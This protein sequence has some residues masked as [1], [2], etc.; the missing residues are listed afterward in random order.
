MPDLSNDPNALPIPMGVRVDTGAPHPPL[1][2]A[3][4]DRFL[5]GRATAPPATAALARVQS[6]TALGPDGSVA[7]RN[8]LSQTGWAVLFAS[9]AD[10]AIKA[11]LQPLLDLRQRQVAKRAIPG[12][13][14]LFRIFEGTDPATGGV[15]LNPDGTPQTAQQW[16]QQHGASLTAA[17]VPS[18][19]PY[20]VL[21]VGSP[22]RIPFSFQFDL[23]A[24]WLVGRL[25]FDDIADYGRYAAHVIAQETDPANPSA[26]PLP[27][28]PANAAVWIT[29]NQGD[30]A[31]TMLANAVSGDFQATD[32]I[33]QAPLGQ[34]WGF[35]ADFS[36]RADATKSRLLDIL[37]GTRGAASILFTGSHGAETS[38]PATDADAAYQRNIQGSLIT[39]S[40]IPNQPAAA[41]DLFGAADIPA[42]NIL[43]GMMVF[44]FACFSAG[45]PAI[46]SYSTNPD[47]S[48]IMIAKAPLISKLAQSLLA[49]GAL[50]VI[51]HVDRAFKYGFVDTSGT[52]QVQMLRTPLE[53][54][55]QGNR[56]GL[57][58]DAF[59]TTWGAIEG[60]LHNANPAPVANAALRMHIA[61]DD[62]RNYTV[63]G[64]PAVRLRVTPASA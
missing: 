37:T 3:D 13:K 62:A 44:L 24:Q 42:Q 31:T 35:A 63:L 11:Q 64:D 25:Y 53:L 48:P 12:R 34:D 36:L 14:P 49:N 47:G 30:V 56:A 26:P 27:P 50:A 52:S 21:I 19:I 8:N 54:L 38:P 43:P 20:Y 1:T 5:A 57:A 60:L 18:V 17:V 29:S 22:E 55:M 6:V 16:T 23:R 4:V 45:C 33:A 58:A 46:D 10:P 32:G 40:W 15:L 7:D 9:D 51:G 28:Q 61:S 2:Q 39:Q 41:A 59:S